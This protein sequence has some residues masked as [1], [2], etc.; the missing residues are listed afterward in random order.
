[1]PGVE[2][3]VRLRDPRGQLVDELEARP[4]Q[5]T[6][7]RDQPVVEHVEGRACVGIAHP[8][9]Q[10]RVA[11]A[12]H[13]LEVGAHRRVPRTA[14]LDQLVE[15]VA[16]ARRTALHQREVVRREHRDAQ[17]VRVVPPAGHRLLV[18]LHPVAADRAQR[19]LDEQRPV[20]VDDLGPHDRLVVPR[21]HEGRVLHSTERPS[22]RH[23]RDGLEQARLALPVR[24]GDHRAAFV[25]RDVDRLVA[26]EVRQP[27][28]LEPHQRLP[29]VRSVRRSAPA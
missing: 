9:L 3:F 1:M 19:G 22:G 23:P 26:A 6:P 11:L 17:V 10:Q 4:H 13:P 14:R 12:Q 8:A 15:V 21:G 2:R 7:A 20:V 5:L 25:E 24:A 27:E 28:A 29:V 18:H 16:P